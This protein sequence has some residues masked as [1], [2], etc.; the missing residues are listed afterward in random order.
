MINHGGQALGHV[1]NLSR[2]ESRARGTSHLCNLKKRL[3]SVSATENY[4]DDY[5]I[6]VCALFILSQ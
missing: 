6:K 1:Q 3:S 5:M 2:G 4:P